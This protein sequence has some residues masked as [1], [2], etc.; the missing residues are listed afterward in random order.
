MAHPTTFRS[1]L[2]LLLLPTAL[3]LA[4]STVAQP[5]FDANL[6]DT[7]V[8]AARLSHYVAEGIT[9][10]PLFATYSYE[11]VGDDDTSLV[12]ATN[13]GVCYI[14]LHGSF[15]SGG[16]PFLDRLSAMF[17]SRYE[18]VCNTASSSMLCCDA[19]SQWTRAYTDMVRGRVAAAVA[20]APC[21]ASTELVLT[22]HQFGAGLAAIA[23]IE[24]PAAVTTLPVRYL[25]FSQPRMLREGC[26]VDTTSWIRFLNTREDLRL[27]II[28]LSYD[29]NQGLF[30][31]SFFQP[32]LRNYGH[33]FVMNEEA[34]SFSYLGE[35]VQGPQTP[36]D[37]VGYAGLMSTEGVD[38]TYT[39]GFDPPTEAFGGYLDRL[40]SYQSNAV[41]S[42]TFPVPT[43]GF[44]RLDLC[45]LDEECQSGV[46]GRRT[47]DAPLR[48]LDP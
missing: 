45:T 15:G 10:S 44:L 3:L 48:C 26:A 39:P 8:S 46:C 4:P 1:S 47:F 11:T 38:T 34:E 33:L 6:L 5:V 16:S 19:R 24:L 35:N 14:A 9:S 37:W 22:G 13:N 23:A 31:E 21:A 29:N 30:Q 17:L 28:Q 27:H 40:R 18:S 25:S 42:A 32:G 20:S 7:S 2:L 41:M 36:F 43:N 12:V